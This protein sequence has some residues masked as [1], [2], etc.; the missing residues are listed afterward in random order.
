[1]YVA[2]AFNM[3]KSK[4]MALMGEVGDVRQ[5]GFMVVFLLEHDP[6]GITNQHYDQKI[7]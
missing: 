7:V 4:S 1:M 6:I 2:L 5:S 3:A